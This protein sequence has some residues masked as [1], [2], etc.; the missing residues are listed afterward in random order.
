MF[1]TAALFGFHL[2]FSSYHKKRAINYFDFSSLV[3][4]TVRV[5]APGGGGCTE[6]IL[7]PIS[8]YDFPTIN[9][10]TPLTN[11]ECNGDSTGQIQVEGLR[12]SGASLVGEMY[13][14]T[15]GPELRPAQNSPIFSNLPVFSPCS[16]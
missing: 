16:Q 8:P 15:V 3:T 9:V 5:T 7:I 11:I 4:L 6:E 2:N 14:I 1:W 13:E 10:V 12:D